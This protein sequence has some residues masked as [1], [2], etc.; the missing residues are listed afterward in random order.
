MSG[1]FRFPTAFRQDP[2]IDSWLKEQRPELAAIAR[3]WF[4]RMRECG[5]DVREV[6]HD[7]CPTACV[8]DAAF[9]YVAVFRTHT[10]VGFFRGAELEDPTGLLEG[11]GK[12]M[13][14]VKVRLDAEL[15]SAAL[16]ALVGR[17]YEDMKLRLAAEQETGSPLPSR[18]DAGRRRRRPTKG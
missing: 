12:S 10:N 6:M 18:Q 5:R 7:G 17:A 16:S 13:R 2:A 11:T 14:H 4:Q 9:G 15:D 8:E 1:L 3:S